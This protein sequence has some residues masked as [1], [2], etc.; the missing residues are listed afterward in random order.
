MLRQ[1]RSRT[2]QWVS[3]EELSERPAED[4]S[5]R[6]VEESAVLEKLE[7]LIRLL[8]PLDRDVLLLCLEGMEAAGI[9]EIV[10]LSASHVAQKVDRTKRVLSRFF[11]TGDDPGS[12]K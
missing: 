7:G 5:E 12:E 4:D 6:A 10:G 8:K 1:K 3:L 2:A 11:Q 9:G